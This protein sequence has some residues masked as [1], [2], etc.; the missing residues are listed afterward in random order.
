MLRCVRWLMVLAVVALVCGVAEPVLACPFCR[1]ALAAKDNR[2]PMAYM[3]SILFMLGMPPTVLGGIGF[4]IYR[5]F[6]KHAAAMA[7]NAS[8]PVSELPPMPAE[9]A[10]R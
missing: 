4:A 5:A 6:R 2:I 7:L 10:T 8:Q 1:E 3:Y 9:L